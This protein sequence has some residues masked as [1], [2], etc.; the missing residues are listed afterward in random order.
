[1]RSGAAAADIALATVTAAAAAPEARFFGRLV[2]VIVL[3]SIAGGAAG[4]LL[5][6]ALVWAGVGPGGAAAFALQV[7]GWT[8]FGHLIA[9]IWAGYAL[10]ADRSRREFAP[11]SAGAP[12]FEVRVR[13]RT[14]GEIDR[15]RAAL[16]VAGAHNVRVA[17]E[18]ECG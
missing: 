11:R 4:A 12:A 16:A 3:W 17:A 2:W 9:G 6:A 15:A 10:L 18:P 7:V 5:G 13:C 1:V 14:R 8:I